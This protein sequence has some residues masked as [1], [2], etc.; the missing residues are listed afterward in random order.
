MPA[1]TSCAADYSCRE[2]GP[3]LDRDLVR[4]G[5]SRLRP[6]AHIQAQLAPRLRS[7]F[8]RIATLESALYMRNQLLRD[9]DWA[10]MAH[11]L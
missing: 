7:A 5:L 6:L 2:L 9:T 3:V 11:G 8:A 10:S 1:P 4:R